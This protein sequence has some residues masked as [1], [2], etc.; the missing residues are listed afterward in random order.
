MVTVETIELREIAHVKG[1]EVEEIL[2][3][4]PH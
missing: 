1:S 4:L 3:T 2:P